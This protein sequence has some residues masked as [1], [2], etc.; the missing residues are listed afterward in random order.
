M[1]RNYFRVAFRNLRKHTG[2]TFINVVGLTVGIACCVMIMLFVQSELG[3]DRFHANADRLYRLNKVVTP[4]T[5]GTERHVISSGPMGPTLAA[6]YPEVEQAVRVLPWFDEILTTHGETSIKLET[7]V[8]VDSNFFDVFSF[9]LLRGDPNTALAAPLSMVLSEETARAFFGNEDPMG[10]TLIGLNG[11]EFTITGIA[12]NPPANSHLTYDALASWSSLV[13]G[14]GGLD[15]GWLTSWFPQAIYTYLLLTPDADPAALEAKLPDF[16]QRHFAERVDQYTLYLQP[17]SSIYLDS[18]DLLHSR[19][20]RMG[21]RTYVHVF[22]IIAVLIL[23]IACINFMNLSTARATKRAREVSMRKVL[24]ANRGQLIRQFLGESFLTTALALVLAVGLVELT[25]PAF[26]TFTGKALASGVWQ[27]PLM[28]LGLVGVLLVVGLLAG[29]YPAFVLSGFR[30]VRV[31]KG[32]GLR[33]SQGAMPRKVL[34]TMQFTI[35]IALIV[36]TLVVYRQMDYV[37]SK[38][39]GFEK[40]QVVV[41]HIENTA[42]SDQFEAFKRTLLDHPRITQAAGS[43]RVPGQGMM[44]FGINPEGLA[45]D[46]SWT[47]AAIRLDDFDLLETYDM[48][49][50]AGRYFDPHYP[51]DSTSAVVINEALAR[52]LGWDD[53]VGKRLDSPGEVEAGTVIGV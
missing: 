41:L 16:M 22:S 35:S 17:L 18:A 9:E 10:Q 28:L 49:L 11:F 50:V 46:E 40:E 39:L 1:L 38:D 33:E 45:Q 3:F 30:P 23:L 14:N 4:Q 31:L 51:T 47:A 5:G 12:K 7:T 2:Y 43:N 19:N 21:N 48:E 20:V 27:N 42:I 32:G 29:A 53:P 13:P 25:L 37:L 36:G 52:S 24:G 15:F 44:S 8:F 26:R 34:V 6:D